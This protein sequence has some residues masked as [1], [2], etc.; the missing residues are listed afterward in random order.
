LKE[1][2]LPVFFAA[3]GLDLPTATKLPKLVASDMVLIIGLAVLLFGAIFAWIVFVRGPKKHPSER[4]TY[5]QAKPQVT[6]TDDGRERVRKKKRQRRRE[7]RQRNPTLAQTGGLP[8]PRD[9]EQ[10]PTI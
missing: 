7:H 10:S 5:L 4:R 9:P 1:P 6:V 2:F 8:P 3:G